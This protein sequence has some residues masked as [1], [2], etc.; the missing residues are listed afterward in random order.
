MAIEKRIESHKWVRDEFE[1]YVED[2]AVSRALFRTVK[3]QGPIYDP[4]CGGGN[5]LKEAALAGYA[6]YGTDV[7]QRATA[8]WISNIVDFTA[9]R[10]VPWSGSIVMNPPFF[11][12]DGT[13]FF[14]RKALKI[15]S[16]KVACFAPLGF[17]ASDGRS[18][19]LFKELPPDEVYVTAPRTSCP[20][21][22]YLEAGNEA[23]GGK[24]DWVWLIWDNQRVTGCDP[25]LK[26][27][28]VRG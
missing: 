10:Y 4:C 13:E 18:Q 24:S 17:L 11:R 9:D 7:I 2:R 8:R 16:G 28:N 12:G 23:Q 15:A 21:G 22:G 26:W 1:W 27:M 25:R 5:I 6:V 20:P 3:F 19:G 14:I